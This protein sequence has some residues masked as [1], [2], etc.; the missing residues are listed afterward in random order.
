[1]VPKVPFPRAMNESSATAALEISIVVILASCCS[2]CNG[3]ER[4][5]LSIRTGFH[6]L[7][8]YIH[9]HMCGTS[10]QFCVIESVSMKLINDGIIDSEVDHF[11]LIN[12]DVTITVLPIATPDSV[13]TSLMT[14]ISRLVLSAQHNHHFERTQTNCCLKTALRSE[15]VIMAFCEQ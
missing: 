6:L 5:I 9:L 15:A 2:Y 3:A 10:R 11:R 8:K 14:S 12:Y 4:S 1:M 7:H 13:S